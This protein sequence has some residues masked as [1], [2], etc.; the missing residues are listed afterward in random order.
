MKAESNH[1]EARGKMI[2]VFDTGASPND[3]R[4]ASDCKRVWIGV[5]YECCETYSRVYR[6][7]SEL[8]YR[9]RCPKCGMEINVRV[10]PNGVSSRILIATPVFG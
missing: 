2:D 1:P 7:P 3:S 9:G 10:G 8:Q 5:F 6:R 4:P